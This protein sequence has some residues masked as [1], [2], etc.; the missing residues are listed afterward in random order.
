L[1]QGRYTNKYLLKDLEN[2]RYE[3]FGVNVFEL[4]KNLDSSFALLKNNSKIEIK[5]NRDKTRNY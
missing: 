1:P 5:R 3:I 2:Y 4:E